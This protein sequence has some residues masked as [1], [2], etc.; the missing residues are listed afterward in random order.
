LRLVTQIGVDHP[1]KRT[2]R[3]RRLRGDDQ[4]ARFRRWP[5]YFSARLPISVRTNP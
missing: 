1:L 3:Q 5:R 2:V 4:P